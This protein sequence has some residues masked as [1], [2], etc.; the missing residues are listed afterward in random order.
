MSN[1]KQ[2]PT[3]SY[4]DKSWFLDGKRP[5]KIEVNDVLFMELRQGQSQETYLTFEEVRKF[6]N[7]VKPFLFD[8]YG[9]AYVEV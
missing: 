3:I 8:R 9:P 2:G 4:V 5:L 1:F 7:A 6:M